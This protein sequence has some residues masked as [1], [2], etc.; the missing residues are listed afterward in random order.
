M[1]KNRKPRLTEDGLPRDGRE[2]LPAD[3][4]DLHEAME[5]AKRLIRERHANDERESVPPTE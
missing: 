2:W 1:K 5:E 3:W 4:Q